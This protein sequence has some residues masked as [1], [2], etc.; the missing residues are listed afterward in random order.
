MMSGLDDGYTDIRTHHF[1]SM[2]E[3]GEEFVRLNSQ[4]VRLRPDDIL[5]GLEASVPVL[6]E[7]R[8]RCPFVGYDMIRRGD[9]API[10]SMSAVLRTWRGAAGDVPSSRTVGTSAM[11]LANDLT[12]EEARPLIEFLTIAGEAFGRDPEYNRL[13]NSLNMVICMWLYR[14]MVVT[15][16]STNTPRLSRESF[17]KCLMSLSA[18]SHYLDWLVGRNLGERD[19]SPCYG[20]VKSIFAHRIQEETGK[21]TRM[22][23]PPWAHNQGTALRGNIYK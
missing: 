9:N 1:N 15:Q 2:A 16:Y 6:L 19:R 11:G 17:K 10:V 4:L 8:K 23:S 3:M 18:N 12:N 7:I 21:K 13:W 5:R 14:R 22:P 20:R